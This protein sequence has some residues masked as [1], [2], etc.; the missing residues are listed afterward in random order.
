[1]L[2]MKKPDF[3]N[4]G[5]L[6]QND[7]AAKGKKYKGSTQTKGKKKKENYWAFLDSECCRKTCDIFLELLDRSHVLERCS[8]S[9]GALCIDP[10]LVLDAGAVQLI[11]QSIFPVDQDPSQGATSLA[12]WVVGFVVRLSIAA[13]P[14]TWWDM[15]M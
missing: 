2:F 12:V 13:T 15:M 11:N 6:Q 9:P 5:C 10:A 14:A 8:G 1:M 3:G 7:S 4:G